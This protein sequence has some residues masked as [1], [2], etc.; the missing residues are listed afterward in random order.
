MVVWGIRFKIESFLFIG[1][2]W[3][4]RIAFVRA[5]EPF[6]DGKRGLGTLGTRAVSNGPGS[7]PPFPCCKRVRVRTV[8]L[9]LLPLWLD[10]V[11]LSC[12]CFLL[13][14]MYYY[15]RVCRSVLRTRCNTLALLAPFYHC[16]SWDIGAFTPDFLSYIREGKKIEKDEGGGEGRFV[17]VHWTYCL[18]RFGSPWQVSHLLTNLKVVA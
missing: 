3:I 9:A 5:W 7:P 8:L 17:F 2:L 6:D 16:V 18:C 1:A 14:S 12:V 10:A 15:E 13:L 4:Q 11:S